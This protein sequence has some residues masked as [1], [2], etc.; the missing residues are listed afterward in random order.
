[1][2]PLRLSV[3]RHGPFT[4]NQLAE[5][6][7]HQVDVAARHSSA[8]ILLEIHAARNHYVVNLIFPNRDSDS[9]GRLC[10]YEVHVKPYGA[11]GSDGCMDMGPKKA[12]ASKA[13]RGS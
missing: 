3:W 12:P 4:F 1:M 9:R 2:E 6:R 8:R 7:Y 11:L 5:M 10:T 13:F